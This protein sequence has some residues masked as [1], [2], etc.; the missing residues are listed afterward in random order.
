MTL[1]MVNDEKLTVDTMKET[2]PWSQYGID[3]VY[4]AYDADE[5][6]T[7]I[8]NNIVDIMLC[9]IEMPGENG[10][11]LLRWVRETGKNIEC[12]FLTCHA[13]F[14]Y[15][16][17]AISLGCQD[18]ILIPAKYD[19]IGKT[20]QKVVNR[21]LQQRTDAKYQEYGKYMLNEQIQQETEIRGKRKTSQDV[22]AEISCY[23]V[24]NLG[25]NEMG[26]NE[27]AEYFSFHPVYLN[28][29][30]KKE[31]GVTVSLFIIHERMKLAAAFLETGE[32]DA[33]EVAEKV[34]YTHYTNFYTMFKKYYGCAPTQYR[35]INFK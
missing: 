4:I 32:Y 14:H 10:L 15:A 31:K 6:K 11:A 25:N 19:E 24:K 30:F 7:C 1:L 2:I 21:L 8:L 33:K 22:V 20:I 16:K 9:D 34:G 17:E 18:Y 35:E 26:V 29:L 13:S 12:I 28:R 23:I 27:L 5:G 3:K